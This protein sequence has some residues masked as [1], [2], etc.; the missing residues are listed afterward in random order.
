MFCVVSGSMG[1]GKAMPHLKSMLTM[2]C[3]QQKGTVASLNVEHIFLEN[4]FWK[5]DTYLKSRLKQ[6]STEAI[7]FHLQS[8]PSNDLLFA[9][10]NFYNYYT[11]TLFSKQRLFTPWER[12]R[13][14]VLWGATLIRS[15]GVIFITL[16]IFLKLG[17][18]SRINVKY[19]L[20]SH[21]WGLL[22]NIINRV[23]LIC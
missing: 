7:G 13:E 11:L 16:W 22:W 21:P 19:I 14:R 15:M 9:M 5:W 4:V 23:W 12:E 3:L 6:E 8:F 2:M 17:Y 10:E 1:A 20:H 18:R